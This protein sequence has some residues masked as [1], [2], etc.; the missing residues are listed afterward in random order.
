[1]S[2]PAPAA[3]FAQSA[4]I[5]AG[6]LMSALVFI[7]LA[8][9]FVLPPTG[10]VPVVALLVQ[11]AAGVA[12]HLALDAIGYRVPPI[13]PGSTEE[14]AAAEARQRWQATMILRFALAEVIAILSVAA[15]FV[16]PDGD[17]VVYLGGAA[18]SLV[19]IAVH[20][21]PGARPVGKVASALE[22]QGARSGLREAFGFSPEGPIQRL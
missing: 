2:T 3:T 18:V 20:V 22:A 1:M 21:W 10:T 11:L 13:A 9:F 8:L 12:V 6:S 16:L 19:L 15:A 17:V 5:L 7:G 14:G 4:R